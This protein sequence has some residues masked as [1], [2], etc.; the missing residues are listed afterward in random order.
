MR[1]LYVCNFFCCDNLKDNFNIVGPLK[2]FNP[3]DIVF[4]RLVN[5]TFISAVAFKC[6]LP[7]KNDMIY[8]FCIGVISREL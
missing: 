7:L 1:L 4:Y 2:Y 6:I 5:M 8:I 3:V